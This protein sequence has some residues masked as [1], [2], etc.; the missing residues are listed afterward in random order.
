MKKKRSLRWLTG[1]AFT[2]GATLLGTTTA[3]AAPPAPDNTPLDCFWQWANNPNYVGDGWVGARVSDVNGVFLGCG[4][5][6][7]GIIHIADPDSTGSIHPIFA[8]TQADFLACFWNI[9]TFGSQRPD[10]DFPNDRTRYEFQYTYWTNVGFPATQTAT[11]IKNNV[12]RFVW[13]MFT[14]TDFS[15]D[16]ND[17]YSCAHNGNQTKK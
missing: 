10:N 1:V 8:D 3:T 4:D 16:G 14:Q 2:L 13:T 7:S 17:W 12:G 5:E 15:P 11:L 9:A 6:L